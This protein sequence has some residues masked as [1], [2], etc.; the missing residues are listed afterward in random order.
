M[1][2]NL[3]NLNQRLSQCFGQKSDLHHFKICLAFFAL[4]FIVS[5]FLHNS[6]NNCVWPNR[7][8]NI[9]LDA[10]LRCNI[11]QYNDRNVLLNCL[12][13]LIITNT[14]FS[15]VWMNL[16]SWWF[17][18]LSGGCRINERKTFI[19]IQQFL[20][21]LSPFHLI[22]L[23]K[24]IECDGNSVN[25]NSKHVWLVFWIIKCALFQRA[26]CNLNLY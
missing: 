17:V 4:C 5:N 7:V 3:S 22:F 11:C 13:G 19:F 1:I 21:I 8:N 14:N 20:V 25:V 6:F 10:I 12:F 23:S 16:L 26:K 18:G 2:V 9:A 15:V 24:P